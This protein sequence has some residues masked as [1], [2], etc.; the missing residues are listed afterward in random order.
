VTETHLLNIG[1]FHM[2][3]SG[4][5]ASFEKL[6]DLATLGPHPNVAALAAALAKCGCPGHH[7]PCLPGNAPHSSEEHGLEAALCIESL[8][9]SVGCVALGRTAALPSPGFCAGLEWG[10]IQNAS[11]PVR[12][13]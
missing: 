8:L 1:N 6:A 9:G 5:S 11:V 10:C 7:R 4:L 13:L 2:K 12:A 3:L